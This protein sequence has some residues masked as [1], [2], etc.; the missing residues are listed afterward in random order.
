ML[1]PYRPGGPDRQRALDWMLDRYAAQFP[2]WEVVV[3]DDGGEGGWSKG[4]AVARA[5]GWASRADM[6]VISDADVWCDEV[7]D[8]VMAVRTG[9]LW[10][11][12]HEK[13]RRLD[14]ESTSQVLRGAP[15]SWEMRLERPEYF[16][17]RGG[18]M[19]VMTPQVLEQVPMDCRFRGWGGEDFSFGDA[20]RC[21]LGAPWRGSTVLWHLWHPPESR[22]SPYIG[23]VESHDLAERYRHAKR[24]LPMMEGLVQEA[25]EA[26]R[27][28]LEGESNV[29]ER[30]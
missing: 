19:V 3:A 13:V 17:V 6:I 27:N 21:L 7:E 10:A 30:R 1:V 16:G 23:S 12:P 2:R 24:N 11:I 26:L 28:S 4:L 8:A 20:L 25:R 9:S 18:G 14:E 22:M 29:G 5:A 15:L